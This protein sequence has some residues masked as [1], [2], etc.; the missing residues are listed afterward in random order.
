MKILLDTQIFLWFITADSK[1][2]KKHLSY[3]TDIKNDIF[4]STAS[5][6]ECIIKQQIGK[7]ELPKEASEYLSEKRIL[8]KIK[9]LAINENSVKHLANLPRIHKDPFD[10]III[11]QSLEHRMGLITVDGIIKKYKLPLLNLL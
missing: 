5:I 2:S 1:L 8:H 11:C 3:L 7:L 10:R 4:L 9:S 6:W